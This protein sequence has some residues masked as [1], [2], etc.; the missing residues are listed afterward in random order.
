MKSYPDGK[1]P[2]ANLLML[3]PKKPK[4][5]SLGQ[6]GH[7]AAHKDRDCAVATVFHVDYEILTEKEIHLLNKFATAVAREV[8]RRD[9]KKNWEFLLRHKQERV[10]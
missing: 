9:T 7:A 3:L 6:I 5:R 8:R 10:D 4:R 1:T 2:L